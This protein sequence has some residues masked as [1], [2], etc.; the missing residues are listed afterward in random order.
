MPGSFGA[1]ALFSLCPG[2]VP[3]GAPAIGPGQSALN[4]RETEFYQVSRN[5]GIG[6][7]H[8]F[9][10]NVAKL[11][12]YFLLDSSGIHRGALPYTSHKQGEKLVGSKKV[13]DVH[14]RE[15]R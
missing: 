8:Y 6:E 15:G 4:A 13:S 10:F 3:P 5:L 12:V 11:C 1:S 7:A 14:A 9:I 2:P